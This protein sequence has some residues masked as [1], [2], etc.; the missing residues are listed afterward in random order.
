MKLSRMHAALS[1]GGCSQGFT[2]TQATTTQA[3]EFVLLY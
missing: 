1:M 3:T 2:A